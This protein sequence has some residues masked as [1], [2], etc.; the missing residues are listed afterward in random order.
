MKKLVIGF[1]L[2]LG[3]VTSSKANLVD[4]FYREKT[5]RVIL[6][7]APSPGAG[8]E[9][10]SR[11]MSRYIAQHL[12]GKPE[13]IVQNV[14][15]GGGITATNLVN[16]NTDGTLL[17]FP[18]PNVTLLG[19]LKDNYN[20]RFSSET[21]NWIGTSD[22]MIDDAYLIITHNEVENDF[23]KIV[24]GD[25]S[26]KMYD[27]PS[28]FH[29]VIDNRSRLIFGYKTKDEVVLAFRRG[30]INSFS[31]TYSTFLNRYNVNEIFSM[32]RPILQFGHKNRI[33]AF[34]NVPTLYEMAKS[35]EERNIIEF[36]QSVISIA[37]PIHVGRNVD[38]SRIK[39]LRA[40]FDAACK[41][42]NL[43]NEFKKFNFPL[44]CMSGEDVQN[45][46]RDRNAS[47]NNVSTLIER[48]FKK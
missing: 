10:N 26:E 36:L 38:N 20:I 41:D 7:T 15:G 40:A 29:R 27:I 48:Y 9:L 18:L 33:S 5:I 14:V 11:I 47:M 16:D 42:E 19:L 2:F 30:E 37:K 21:L 34:S 23:S 25:T 8:L 4:D 35:D 39:L 24:I 3:F 17:G 1:L 43:K 12:P 31:I 44:S 28:I 6:G 32:S 46:I 45:T 13:V 22:S